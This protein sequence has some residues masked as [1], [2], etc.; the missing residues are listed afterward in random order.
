MPTIIRVTRHAIAISLCVLAIT[1]PFSSSARIAGDTRKDGVKQLELVH[2]KSEFHDGI[3][4]WELLGDAR[5]LRAEGGT[6][7]AQDDGSV[8]WFFSAPPK[9]LGDVSDS[10]GATLTYA[11]GHF[12][13]D[14]A[15]K[16]P[17]QVEDVVLISDAFNMTLIRSGLIAPWI[18][19]S[20]VTVRLEGGGEWQHALTGEACTDHEIKRALSSLSGLLI[21]GGYYHGKE[22][23]WVR[24]VSLHR[25]QTAPPTPKPPG[26]SVS[27]DNVLP[28]SLAYVSGGDTSFM[29]PP[30]PLTRPEPD[31]L[32]TLLSTQGDADAP[33]SKEL[34]T[35]MKE[36]KEE[37]EASERKMRNLVADLQG[38]LAA[39]QDESQRLRQA[40]VESKDLANRNGEL[41]DARTR[42]LKHC[43]ASLEEAKSERREVVQRLEVSETLRKQKQ[44]VIE[45]LQDGGSGGKGELERAELRL[46]NCSQHLRAAHTEGARL[47]GEVEKLHSDIQADAAA[48]EKALA[49]VLVCES[50]LDGC[51]GEADSV[52]SQLLAPMQAILSQLATAEE[53][54]R[55]RDR[56]L[57]VA[58]LTRQGNA[59]NTIVC[60]LLLPFGVILVMAV[61]T[62]ASQGR[63]GG[64][65]AR[66]ASVGGLVVLMMWV[67]TG[68]YL[69]YREEW[70]LARAE[71]SKVMSQW[72]E[73]EVVMGWLSRHLETEDSPANLH[74]AGGVLYGVVVGAHLVS[75]M[76]AP[77]VVGTLQGFGFWG[78]GLHYYSTYLP[79]ISSSAQGSAGTPLNADPPHTIYIAA[80]V[81]LSSL[82]SLAYAPPTRP[83]RQPRTKPPAP[84]RPAGAAVP[85]RRRRVDDDLYEGL[86]GSS[87]ED[88]SDEEY[89][90]PEEEETALRFPPDKSRDVKE[91]LGSWVDD[92]FQKYPLD[93]HEKTLEAAGGK[94]VSV[95][96]QFRRDVPT[97]VRVNGK[98]P[99][100]DDDDQRTLRAFE[101]IAAACGKLSEGKK[102]PEKG[103]SVEEVM[104]FANQNLGIYL[105]EA[106]VNRYQAEDS[107]V[108]VMQAGHHYIDIQAS[109]AGGLVVTLVAYFKLHNADNLSITPW[110]IQACA[111]VDV[112]KGHVVLEFSKPVPSPADPAA[113]IQALGAP[114]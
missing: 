16:E 61:P 113:A 11:L 7:S 45:T 42:N 43:E 33:V 104:G 57:A 66:V 30:P 52:E 17:A 102:K 50:K 41:A 38:R 37:L 72:K 26:P 9:F 114:E 87:E 63:I 90:I 31:P 1:I 68:A 92:F 51:R 103:T 46:H 44:A 24:D 64:F 4:G 36:L 2:A 67:C 110:L 56:K 75:L 84:W 21:R 10:F 19:S 65:L 112:G 96:K 78:V 108:S 85:R 40:L 99:P 81:L 80:V 74:L 6:L 91:Q 58:C 71:L 54:V 109:D 13:S 76:V 60:L 49:D 53:S 3:D 62:I 32:S 83:T 97:M 5:A 27:P 15:G 48:R 25:L 77:N 23:T 107:S 39:S 79:P 73:G 98:Q 105:Y 100:G 59:L 101:A 106:V 14:S 18:Y 8:L 47:Q 35:T 94:N 34:F 111:S 28:P 12:H 55:E 69:S 93:K 95:S 20:T 29:A 88:Y 86:S 89:E 22:T 82:S 70:E